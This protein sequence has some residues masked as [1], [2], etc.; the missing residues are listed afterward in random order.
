MLNFCSYS[1]NS[2]KELSQFVDSASEVNLVV[3]QHSMQTSVL[4]QVEDPCCV[5]VGLSP[6]AES[7]LLQRRRAQQKSKSLQLNTCGSNTITEVGSVS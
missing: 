3:L 1:N 7:R 2:A 6:P 5:V 4:Q